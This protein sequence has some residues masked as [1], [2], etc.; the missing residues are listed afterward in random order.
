MAPQDPDSIKERDRVSR[1][2]RRR[3]PEGGQ[4]TGTQRILYEVRVKIASDTHIVTAGQTGRLLADEAWMRVRS[5]REST[6]GQPSP[7]ENGG[8]SRA[9][10]RPARPPTAVGGAGRTTTGSSGQSWTG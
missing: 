4:V 9:F 3:R 1:E 6:R 8:A 2:S 5:F 7:A 10:Q